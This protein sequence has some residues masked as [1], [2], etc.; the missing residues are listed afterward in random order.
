MARDE[1]AR[2]SI[3]PLV[4][5]AGG[6]RYLARQPILDLEGRVFAY[7]LLFRAGPEAVFRGE[8]EQATRTML[9]NTVLYGLEQ[10]TGGLP[11]FV[12]C[13]AQSLT[14]NLV[15]ILPP[16]NTVLEILET[17]EPT[18]EV[19]EAC[20]Q[21]KSRG[22][23][24][25]L[26]DF[27]WHPRLQPLVEL[28]DFIKIDFQLG[29]IVE[30]RSLLKRCAGRRLRMLAEKVETQEEYELARQ[31]G[32]TLFQGYYFC[33]PTL[34]RNRQ[35]PANRIFQLKILEQLQRKPLD[36]AAVSRMLKSDAALTYRLL[37]L[38]N[39]PA[40][41]FRQEVRSIKA[42]L[43]A[44]G[45]D[46]FRRVATLAI[47]GEMSSGQ[48]EALLHMALTRA[49]FCERSAPL[50]DLDPTEQYLLGMLS[51]LPAMLRLPMEDLTPTLPLRD[52]IR[53]ALEGGACRERG[54]LAWLE[55]HE[56]GNWEDC[57]AAARTCG[58]DSVR[59]AAQYADA[60]VW[61][62]LALSLKA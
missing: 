46:V 49:R 24:L 58:L 10:L 22:F 40:Y 57:D 33:R 2:S 13:T 54:L 14:S 52:E 50:C 28:A 47:A 27:V 62:G 41:A 4:E 60:L 51:L 25:A 53:R 29:S 61:A 36:L 6:F 15:E 56:Q 7:E 26:D 34:L 1:V 16:Q 59:L 18:G 35:V 48:P 21:L 19:L 38:V 44:V 39:S 42:A 32:F 45:E 20:Q 12:N 5:S 11:A 30:R 3:V 43:I 55:A 17:V 37:R 31:D 8:A 23:R 9:D